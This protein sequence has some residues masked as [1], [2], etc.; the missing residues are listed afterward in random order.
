MDSFSEI[1]MQML[2]LLA[3]GEFVSGESLGDALGMSRAAVW[4]HVKTLREAGLDLESVHG[5]GYRLIPSLEL[6][7]QA[8]LQARLV[9]AGFADSCI[10]VLGQIDSTNS[11]LMKKIASGG[12][13]NHF[14][15]AEQQTAGRGRRGRS[16]Y[17]PFA[18]NFYASVGWTFEFAPSRLAGLSLAVGVEVAKVLESFIP[19]AVQLKWPNDIYVNDRKLG[20]ILIEMQGEASGPCHVVIGLGVNLSLSPEELAGIGQPAAGMS[21]FASV[22]RNEVAG[23]L[24][25]ALRRAVERFTTQG[26]T[27]FAAEWATRDYLC[28]KEVVTISSDSPCVGVMVGVTPGGE[29]RLQSGGRE[30]IVNSGEVTVRVNDASVS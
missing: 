10:E 20:G 7:E 27:G 21:E 14:C 11:Y 26:F 29:L 28:G 5:K 24:L 12:G 3:S 16:W 23:S 18:R 9:E 25:V 22:S 30:F 2:R 6:L 4:K 13:H 15:L 1:E 8:V 17:S 19:K